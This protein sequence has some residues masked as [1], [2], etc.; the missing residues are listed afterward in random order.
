MAA[1]VAA[2]AGEGSVMVQAVHRFL[3]DQLDLRGGSP[4]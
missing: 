2:G 4:P 3:A 1:Q